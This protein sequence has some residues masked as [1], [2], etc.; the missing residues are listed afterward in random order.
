[1]RVD[2]EISDTRYDV[3]L[4]CPVHI[5]GSYALVKNSTGVSCMAMLRSLDTRS[6][7]LKAAIRHTC[8]FIASPIHT[9]TNGYLCTKLVV[10]SKG[11]MSQV[12][13]SVKGA[14]EPMAAESSSPISL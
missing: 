9:H 12:G 4:D 14:M 5:K 10:P 11:S 7:R 6:G 13:S 3:H 1:M 8:F 2:E